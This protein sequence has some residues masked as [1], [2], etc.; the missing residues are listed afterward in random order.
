MKYRNGTVKEIKP[1]G[2]IDV[3]FMNGDIKRTMPDKK[4]VVYYYKEANTKHTTFED[5][6]EIY[7]FPNG[8]VEKHSSDGRKEICFPDGTRKFIHATGMQES[9]FPDG[10]IVREYENDETGYREIVT[11][12]IGRAL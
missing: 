7:E 8:Q 11:P 5:G 3:R 10:H 2:T 9:L 1:N 12:E 4:V 6:L